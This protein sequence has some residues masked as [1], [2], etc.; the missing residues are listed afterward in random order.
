MLS[1][2]DK[3]RIDSHKLI[4]HPENIINWIRGK[5]IYPIYAEISPYGGCNHRCIFCALDY[6]KYKPNRLDRKILKHFL[7][8]I[9][10]KGVKSV[11]LA[12]EGEP[13][14]HEDIAEIVVYAKSCGLDTAITTNGVLLHN[15]LL[16]NILPN[17]SWI[18]ISLNAGTA[19]SYAYIHKAKTGDFDRVIENIKEASRLKREKGYSCTVGVQLLLLKENYKEVANLA[20]TIREIGADYLIIKPYSQHRSSV[21]RLKDEINYKE[22]LFL[23]DGLKKYTGENFQI[24]F[25]KKTVLK[26]DKERPYKKCLGLPFW[27]YLTSLG[28]LYACSAFLNDDRFCYGNIYKETFDKIWNGEKRKKIMKMMDI[29]WNIEN[30]RE[31][32]RLDEINRFLWRLKHPPEHVNFI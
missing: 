5:D 15:S 20:E 28:D 11:M 19:E 1:A 8:E 18:K 14:M 7:A 21:N 13:L 3:Y 29:G 32:C 2:R 6:L 16:I 24:I 12:G 4:Y 27:M 17:L 22:L 25:R 23:E 9:A 10:S 26:I 30:C 31:V